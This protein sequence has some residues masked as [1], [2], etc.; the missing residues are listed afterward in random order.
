MGRRASAL[1]KE[2]GISGDTLARK[3][4]IMGLILKSPNATIPDEIVEQLRLEFT[5]PVRLPKPPAKKKP[6]AKKP[7]AAPKRAAKPLAKK[8]PKKVKKPAKAEK[9][10]KPPEPKVVKLTRLLTV[11]SLASKFGLKAAELTSLCKGLGLKVIQT[12]VLDRDTVEILA[13]DLK[14][15]VEFNFAAPP[16][17]AEEKT[18]EAPEAVAEVEAPERKEVEGTKETVEAVKEIKEEE[19]LVPRSPVVTF[20]GHVDHG[21]TSLLDVIRKTNVVA[22]EVGGITQHI[23][24]YKVSVEGHSIVFLDTP[25]HEA[26]T[27]MRRRGVNVTDICVLVIAADDGVMPQTVEAINHA[28]EAGVPILVAINKIDKPNASPDRVR[29][30]LTE[31]DLSPEEWGGETICVEVSAVTGEGIDHLLE[32]ILLQAEILELRAD[33]KS[34]AKGVVIESSVS[35]GRGTLTTVI[36]KNGTLRVSDYIVAGENLGKVRALLDERGNRLKEAGPS[37]PVEILGLDGVPQVG[38]EVSSPKSEREARE[39][40]RQAKKPIAQQDVAEL[41]RLTLEEFFTTERGQEKKELKVIIKG[42]V[43]GSVEALSQSIERLSTEKVSP[44]IIHSNV[45]EVNDSDVMLAAASGAIIMAFHSK[46]SLSAADMARR[47][48]VVIESFSVIYEA[49]DRIRRAMEGL[50]PPE[51][52]E[53]PIGRAEIREIFASSALGNLA[54]CYVREGKVQSGAIA[55]LIRDGEQ[56]WKGEVASLQRFKD[57]VK[58]IKSG[59]ECGI[60]LKGQDDIQE[61]DTIEFFVIEKIPQTL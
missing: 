57:A 19:I 16:V 37:A 48:N 5:K 3:C 32:M 35:A 13:H 47:E 23:G 2:L 15:E 17:E 53:V 46:V 49:I 54:G 6:K 24:A 52:R 11:R 1:A 43:L 9:P 44:K 41:R 36:V 10:E 12:D 40:A 60:K 28:R 18:V 45:G 50:L 27:E 42:D 38:S 59:M 33:P 7:V 26:F 29:Q 55:Q 39:I 21:K 4:E 61:G 58:E 56:I 34:R 22:G 14:Y 51:E 8:P 31:R 30:Q 20:I 25:G